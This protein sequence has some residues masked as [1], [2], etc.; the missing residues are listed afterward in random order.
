[1]GEIMV[2]NGCVTSYSQTW[3]VKTMNSSTHVFWGSGIWMLRG[4]YV[5]G[6]RQAGSQ[7]CSLPRLDWAY[8]ICFWPHSCG[9]WQEASVPWHVGLSMGLLRTSVPAARGM[10]G[11]ERDWEM[12]HPAFYDLLSWSPIIIPALFYSLSPTHTQQEGLHKGMNT[13]KQR[14]LEAILEAVTTGVKRS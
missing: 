13:R 12:S 14:S 6:Y 9:C 3:R 10:R 5:E 8:R 4:A 1:M 7:G 11:R 2:I